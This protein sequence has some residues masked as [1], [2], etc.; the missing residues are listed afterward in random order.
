MLLSANVSKI[1]KLM[2]IGCTK[3]MLLILA[4]KFTVPLRKNMTNMQIITIKRKILY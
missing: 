4:L 2:D 1:S 3:P